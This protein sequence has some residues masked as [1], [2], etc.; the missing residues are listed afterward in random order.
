M[1]RF[2]LQYAFSVLFFIGASGIPATKAQPNILP[3][4]R[5]LSKHKKELRRFPYLEMIELKSLIPSII[6]DLRYASPNNFM[7]RLMYPAGTNS[8]YLRRPA[9]DSLLKVQQELKSQGLGIK[10]F[11]AYRPYSVT[12]HFWELVKDERY[13][14]NP[15]KGSNHNRGTAIDLTIIDIKIGE[16][17]DMGTGFDHFSDTAHHSF[18]QLPESVLQNREKLKNI[19]LK[20]GFAALSTEWWHYTYQSPIRFPV[21]DISFKKLRRQ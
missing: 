4:E 15:A 21:L 17:L 13:V 5:S 16:E 1:V 2:A 8:T 9:A 19:M 3:V 10:I 14:A 12:Q 6:Y 18:K 7:Q 20:Y 11:D